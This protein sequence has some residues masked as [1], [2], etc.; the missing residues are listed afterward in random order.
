MIKINSVRPG[1]KLG[2][3]WARISD[4]QSGPSRPDFCAKNPGHE[5]PRF[6]KQVKFRPDPKIARKPAKLG[7]NTRLWREFF[8]PVRSLR[9]QR[10]TFLG[11]GPI[12]PMITSSLSLIFNFI[13]CHISFSLLFNSTD[14]L[15]THSNFIM[16]PS[17]SL[18]TYSTKRR[19]HVIFL[20]AKKIS[21]A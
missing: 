8:C 13:L 9:P 10:A 16:Y 11:Q 1:S 18:H 17:Y 21:S 7:R 5:Q 19:R 3:F 4:L 20:L 14:S 12:R 2:G 6:E 15:H